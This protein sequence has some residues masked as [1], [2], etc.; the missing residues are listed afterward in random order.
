M[1]AAAWR[2]ALLEIL[3]APGSSVLDVGAGT[4]A[5]ALLAA[6]LGYRVTAL[7]LSSGM[8]AKA[9]AK[10]KERRLDVEFV[11]GS[12]DSPPPGP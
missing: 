7:D 9:R 11:V 1:E 5:T 8:L 12:S 6:E 3:P 2:A 4:G 10:A